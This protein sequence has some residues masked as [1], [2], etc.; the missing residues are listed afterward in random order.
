MT[1]LLAG[2][3]ILLGIVGTV[4]PFLP[5]P[6]LVAVGIVG[7]AIVVGTQA[8][9]IAAAIGIVVLVT[10]AVAKWWVPARTVSG[11]VDALPLIVGGVLAVIGFFVVPVIGLIL[12]FILGVFATELLR[13]RSWQRA[14]P[15]T[16]TALKAAGLQMLIELASVVVAGS[17]WLA[18]MVLY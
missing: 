18:A 16:R 12:G 7:Y 1:E 4:I 3:V 5:G 14:W 10:G 13:T 15:A 17:V 2:A 6:V 9:W 11:D 8:A